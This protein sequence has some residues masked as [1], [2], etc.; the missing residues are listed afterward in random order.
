MSGR[1][2]KP[3]WLKIVNG[4]PGKRPLN[5]NEP[6]PVGDLTSAPDWMSPSQK[7]GWD[8]AIAH[9]PRGLLKLIDRSV[10]AVWVVAEDTHRQ[11]SEKVTEQGLLMTTKTGELV[12]STYLPI[13]NR[14]ALI[15]MKAGSELGF[16]P[17]AR[18]RISVPPEKPASR[19]SEFSQP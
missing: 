13:Q 2:P 7:E 8:Y 5:T 17:T 19:F 10:L 15:M 6:Q 4:N 1:K 12:Q 11:A 18:A 14:Q 9:S 3:T 16:S